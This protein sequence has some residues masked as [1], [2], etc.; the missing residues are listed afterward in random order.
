[1]FFVSVENMFLNF[2]YKETCVCVAGA[3]WHA[4]LRFL[5]AE[6][7]QDRSERSSVVATAGTMSRAQ[8]DRYHDRTVASQGGRHHWTTRTPAS[9]LTGVCTMI[10][11][12]FAQPGLGAS[13][14]RGAAGDGRVDTPAIKGQSSATTMAADTA[15]SAAHVGAWAAHQSSAA[16]T[17]GT[18]TTTTAG[19]TVRCGHPVPRGDQRHVGIR[20]HECKI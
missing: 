13:R 9:L 7:F 11:T 18:S 8:C 1:M 5:C 16:T 17:T 6:C 4:S 20:P 14:L 15:V 3:V 10:I 12:C 2:S 19:A